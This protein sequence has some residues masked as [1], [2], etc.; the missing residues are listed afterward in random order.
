MELQVKPDKYGRHI[1]NSI[2]EMGL[3]HKKKSGVHY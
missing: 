3:Q 1:D 2:M